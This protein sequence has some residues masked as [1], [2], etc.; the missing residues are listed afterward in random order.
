ML[1]LKARNKYDDLTGQEFF[2]KAANAAKKL[3]L[4][5]E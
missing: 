3:A 4:M 1:E 2:Q 5:A